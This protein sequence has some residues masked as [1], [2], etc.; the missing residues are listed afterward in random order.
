MELDQQKFGLRQQH[1]LSFDARKHFDINIK[2]A[3]I[4]LSQG[5]PCVLRLGSSAD[6]SLLIK[7]PDASGDVTPSSATLGDSRCWFG[8]EQQRADPDAALTFEHDV[9]QTQRKQTARAAGPGRDGRVHF[10]HVC[11]L[12]TKT[13]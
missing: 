12:K 5:C 6:H 4:F 2:S 10:S 9:P 13:K 8:T 1:D 7:D 11:P 3:N